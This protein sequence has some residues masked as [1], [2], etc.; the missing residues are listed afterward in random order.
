MHGV[1]EE[2][3]PFPLDFSFSHPALGQHDNSHF[4]VTAA[5]LGWLRLASLAVSACQQTA[6]Q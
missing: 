4:T 6:D 2:L 1:A 3:K 5:R